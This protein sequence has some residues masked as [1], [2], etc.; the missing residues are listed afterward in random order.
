MYTS[1]PYDVFK[2]LVNTCKISPLNYYS[3]WNVTGLTMEDQ[4]LMT[5]MKLKLDLTDL[6]LAHR[7]NV[8]DS[9]VSNVLHTLISALHEILFGE[10]MKHM[11]S[12]L[13]CKGS[14]P[15]SFGNFSNCRV[16]IDA[17]EITQDI[18]G[19]LTRKN[20]T[21]SHYKSRHTVKTVVGVSPNGAIVFV[22]PMY[23]GSMSDKAIVEHCELLLQLKP[24]DLVLA[25]KGFTIFDIMP[26]GV[27]LNIPSFLIGKNYFTRE[28]ARLNLKIAKARIH[29][30]RA[31]ER[32]KNFR[33]LAHIPA[34][35]RAFSDKIFQLCCALVN[36]QAPLIKEITV[37]YEM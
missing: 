17:T 4:V 30:E 12:L 29:I 34:H 5:L 14:M 22:S 21:Y 10:C 7:F 25:D 8:S 18:P 13:K 23:P 32:I 9:T 20:A 28:E 35:Y 6:D 2:I 36:L 31:N 27:S 11:P 15:G 16:V 33:I 24:G 19:D 26:A 37:G 1:L 3:G